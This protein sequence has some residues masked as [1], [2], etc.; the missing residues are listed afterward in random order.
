[1]DSIA[2]I[3]TEDEGV[4]YEVPESCIGSAKDARQTIEALIKA[5]STR[6]GKRAKIN[7][8]WNGN[9]PWPNLVGK[10]QG[11]RANFTLREFEGFVG[12]AKT[13]YYALAFKTERFIGLQI[14]YGMADPGLLAKWASKIST[15]YQYA[16]DDDKTLDS[17]MQ[18][19]QVQMVVH[20]VG[21]MVW[22]DI[23]DWKTT[24]RMAGQLLIPDD[25]SADIEDWETVGCPRSY[26]PTKLWNLVKKESSAE[27]RGWN[28]KAVKR[29]IMN[30]QPDDVRNSH[31]NSWERYEQDIRKGSSG[32]DARSKKIFV[33]D[34]F[35]KEFTGR[36]SHF[37]LLKTDDAPAEEDAEKD[38]NAG[39]LFRK[40]GLFEAFNE[41][42][43]PFIYDVGPD[44]DWQSIKGAGPKIFD[45]CSASDRLT[46]RGLD[47]AM[48]AT[49]PVLKAKD[50][51]A[52]SQ[53]AITAI[54]GATVVGPDYEVM[55]QRSMPD[56]QSPLL[57]KRD[58]Q[59]TLQSN[60]GQYRQRVSEENQ[61]P[62][63]GQ[64]QMNM[65]QQNVLGDGDA[66]RYYKQLD[67]FHL[68]RF[69]RLLKMGK[70][71]YTKRK[72]LTPA[73]IEKQ[74]ALTNSEKLALKFY[75]GCVQTDGIPEQIM[76]FENF[77][78]IKAMRLVGNGSA[79]MEDMIGD[80]LLGLL[81]VISN[82]RGRNFIVRN[83]ITSIAGEGFADAIEPAYDTPQQADSHI[84]I[85]TLENN[86]LKLP[87]AEVAISPEQDHVTH[88]GVHLQSVAQHAEQVQAGQGDPHQLLLHL[89]QTGP[90]THE[91]LRAISSDP[92]RKE[93]V[94]GM[95]KAWLGMSKMTDQLAQQVQEMDEAAAQQQPQQAPDPA[96]IAALAEVSGKL[97]IKG[98]EAMGKLQ[99]KAQNQRFTQQLKAQQ[100]AFKLQQDD[101]TT[102]HALKLENLKTR[103]ELDKPE[104]VAA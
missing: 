47:G 55:Q 36:V 82:E 27:A 32:F 76:E 89:E 43:C 103:N 62:T 7:G 35:Q 14:D 18:R 20:G 65:Q 1:M 29:A 53:T 11:E 23:D 63:L 94:E 51:K 49:G 93:Q 2:T 16:N 28:V 22:E 54:A 12:A 40:I 10:G 37:I 61:E 70:R 34:L 83:R 97:E 8:M 44:G 38:D 81:P 45:Y 101:I 87:G 74:T 52:L 59:S 56:L 68:E 86:A 85:A 4:T 58:L 104:A 78:R 77:C 30:A 75:K 98:K 71:L 102:A 69:R 84:S 42:L 100:Q 5:E 3:T 60:T 88:F 64:A 17:H 26:Y 79:Q 39:F 46:M 13:P 6:S 99:L 33:A 72:N 66:T 92:T 21:P 95:Q 91:H 90:H 19:S 96:L 15:R 24:S 67:A 31:G 41:I 48:L 57:M 50:V 25:H 80:K 73:D 9:K